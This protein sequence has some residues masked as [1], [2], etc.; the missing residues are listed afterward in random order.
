MFGYEISLIQGF[1]K[2]LKFSICLAEISILSDVS[3]TH[4][5]KI[6]YY[7]NNHDFIGSKCNFPGLLES[8]VHLVVVFT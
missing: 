3:F 6:V 5:N 1:L 4:R 7:I 8:I 2:L